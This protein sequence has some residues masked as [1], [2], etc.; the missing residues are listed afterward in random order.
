MNTDVPTVVESSVTVLIAER[1]LGVGPLV[2][3]QRA[4]MGKLLGAETTA[5]GLLAR[6]GLLVNTG[7]EAA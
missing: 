1:L 3:V 6:V 5:I 7:P 4:G 2:S